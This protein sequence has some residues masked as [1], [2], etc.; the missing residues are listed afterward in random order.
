M[1]N[2][3]ISFAKQHYNFISHDNQSV[4]MNDICV[5]ISTG[6]VTEKQVNFTCFKTLLTF[7]GY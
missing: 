4:I 2:N 7:L 5:D 3:Q 6:Q 1:N